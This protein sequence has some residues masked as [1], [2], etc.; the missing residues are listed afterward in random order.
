MHINPF[1]RRVA[2]YMENSKRHLSESNMSLEYSCLWV[3]MILY[4]TFIASYIIS[5][6]LSMSKYTRLHQASSSQLLKFRSLYS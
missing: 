5:R 3:E 2:Y 6:L 4:A 1:T